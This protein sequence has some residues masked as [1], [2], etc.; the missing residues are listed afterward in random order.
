MIDQK[1]HYVI[2]QVSS[3]C[4]FLRE[5]Q[6]MGS[7]KPLWLS[8]SEMRMCVWFSLSIRPSH[9]QS[10]QRPTKSIS[11][12]TDVLHHKLIFSDN[13]EGHSFTAPSPI[14][15]QTQCLPSSFP[16][17]LTLTMPRPPFQ[18][19]NSQTNSD[20]KTKQT[21]KTASYIIHNPWD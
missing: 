9:Q 14:H 11:P 6:Q 7:L 10:H 18:Q 15:S 21:N 16:L 20:T 5:H 8:L 19:I 3:S 2:E 12:Q 13:M 17:T 1:M 4:V